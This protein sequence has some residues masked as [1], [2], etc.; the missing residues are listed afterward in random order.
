[1]CSIYK[2]WCQ[3][4]SKLLRRQKNSEQENVLSIPV[5]PGHLNKIAQTD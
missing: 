2:T 3:R 4:A 5:I 1:M